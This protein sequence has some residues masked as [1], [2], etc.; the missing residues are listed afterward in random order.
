MTADPAGVAV[1]RH[2]AEDHDDG[3]RAEDSGSADVVLAGVSRV[4]KT[5]VAR[6][7]AGFG[8]RAA[9]VPVV[10]GAVCPQQAVASGRVP[11]IA[12]TLRVEALVRRRRAR[13]A[14]L[15]Q[16]LGQD[17]CR[18]DAVRREL[19]AARRLFER[20]GWPVIDVTGQ[21]AAE[22]AVLVLARLPG[23]EDKRP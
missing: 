13:M 22:A 8:V 5:S 16:S 7:L 11:V 1:A 10:D 19:I 21:S 6:V 15:G 20:E 14:A 12:L 9:N 3:Q 17:Y 18:L 4:S 23:A 2:F